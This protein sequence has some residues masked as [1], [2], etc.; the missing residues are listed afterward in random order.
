MP[1]VTVGSS[2]HWTRALPGLPG[3][4]SRFWLVQKGSGLNLSL[5]V[6]LNLQVI[7]MN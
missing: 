5:I 6:N 7:V 1:G 4:T 3:P 2:R